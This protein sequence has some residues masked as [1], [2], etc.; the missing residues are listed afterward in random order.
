[1]GWKSGTSK[2]LLTIIGI[3]VVLLVIDFALFQS[4]NT[5]AL[6]TAIQT[7]FAINPLLSYGI[8]GLIVSI[9]ILIT[10]L[11]YYRRRLFIRSLKNELKEAERIPL[12]D[13]AQKLDETPAKVEV[14]LN[15]MAK[16]KVTKFQGMLIISQ[17]KHVYMGEKLLNKIIE[18][19]NEGQPRG[20]IAN[21]NQISRAELDK[22]IE[23]LIEEG[24]IEERE[25]KVTRKVRPSYR[26]GT[27]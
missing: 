15:R 20:E 13:L 11:L 8:V 16:S 26:R 14:E 4:Q 5:I 7:A 17:G 2:V 22:T 21:S 10:G 9:A 18:S 24:R 23:L 12:I 3:A 27:K 6:V 25:E 19:Y 1:M